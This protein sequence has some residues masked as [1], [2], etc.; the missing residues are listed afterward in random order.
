[1]NGTTTGTAIKGLHLCADLF[2]ETLAGAT[3]PDHLHI[4][5]Y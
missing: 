1:M 2:V 4:R 5:V 3:I